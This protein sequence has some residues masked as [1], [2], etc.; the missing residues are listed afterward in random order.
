MTLFSRKN[1]GILFLFA[2]ML[3]VSACGS[4]NSS[5]SSSNSPGQSQ[6]G[7]EGTGEAQTQE[8]EELIKVSIA[9]PQDI[10]SFAPLYVA[11]AK[12]FFEE[13]GI[14]LTVQVLSG[15]SQSIQALSGDSV[16]FSDSSSTDFLSTVSK[17]LDFVAL[18]ATIMQTMDVAVS[19]EWAE[20]K[21]VDRSSPIED[22]IRALEGAVIGS[23]GPG[24]VSETYPKWLVK[25]VGLDPEK[26]LEVIAIGG[27]PARQ[28]ALQS[29]QIQAY[30]SSPPGPEQA[31]VDGFGYVLIPPSDVPGFENFV[32]EVLFAKREYVEANP[33][34]V[35]KVVRAISRGN[36]Y[37]LDNPEESK[38]LIQQF[39][40]EVDERVLSSSIDNIIGQ[41]PR[42]G[43]MSQEHWDFVLQFLK[44]IGSDVGSLD[45]AEGGF[46]TNQYN[47]LQ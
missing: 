43:R 46:W 8:Q 2:M 42:N 10:L 19:K 39:F 31:E 16:Q 37:L 3:L 18:Q 32:H 4:G 35:K 17:G 21:G 33:E 47:D 29:G 36:N 9:Q 15:G 11:R 24:A 6:Q 1:W 38:K 40:P 22:R 44:E 45:T 34:V 27:L 23:T 26:A 7:G 41:V 28:A 20:Q 25:K 5:S 12:G 13:E 30:V 14:D